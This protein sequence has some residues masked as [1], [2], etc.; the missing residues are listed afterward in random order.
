MGEQTKEQELAEA[1]KNISVGITRLSDIGLNERAIIT[2]INDSC[3][4]DKMGRR[5]GKTQIKNILRSLNTLED[6]YCRK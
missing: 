1:I 5:P 2:L 6:K 3:P 4:Y